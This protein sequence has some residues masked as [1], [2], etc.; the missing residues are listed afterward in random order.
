MSLNIFSPSEDNHLAQGI[1]K[2]KLNG[3]F[4]VE[5][6]VFPD[7]R[8]FFA[9]VAKIP[10]LNEVGFEF[11]PE[12]GQINWAEMV[13]NSIKGFHTE[14]WRKLITVMSG[15]A[16][17]AIADVRPESETFKEVEVF[18]LGLGKKCLR[19]SLLLEAGLG[20]SVCAI[21]GPVQYLYITDKMYKDRD[22]SGDQAISLF[23]PELG[24]EW[25][26]TK[27][28][29]IISERDKQAVSLKE[30]TKINP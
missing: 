10:E 28:Q 15:D 5:H 27:E 18:R 7:D 23:D 30:L 6:K 22:P 16:F 4:Y 9:E 8:G 1:H 25:P 26:I 14:D 24:V 12:N 21:T 3:L 20:N 11:H 17:C 13:A 29:M 2:T 19:G